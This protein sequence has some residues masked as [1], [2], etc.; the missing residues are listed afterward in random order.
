MQP[1]AKG[2]FVGCL[3][4]GLAEEDENYRSG[5]LH[6]LV[7]LHPLRKSD[8]KEYFLFKYG[9]LRKITH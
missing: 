6:W 3:M 2:A 9:Y 4:W 1:S 8:K 5:C 7:G